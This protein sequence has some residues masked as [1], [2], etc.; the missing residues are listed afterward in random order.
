MSTVLEI[1][2]PCPSTESGDVLTLM[3]PPLATS[4]WCDTH[5]MWLDLISVVVAPTLSK[6]RGIGVEKPATS[7]T[8]AETKR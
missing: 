4:F 7:G 6:L 3:Q 2:C 8:R 1:D 5:G